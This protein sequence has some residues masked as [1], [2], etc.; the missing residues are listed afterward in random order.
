MQARGCFLSYLLYVMERCAKSKA[1]CMVCGSI[2]GAFQ[3]S[4]SRCAARL[5]R[6][7]TLLS[8][9][10]RRRCQKERDHWSRVLEKAETT[11]DPPA[12]RCQRTCQVLGPPPNRQDVAHAAVRCSTRQHR[13]ASVNDVANCDVAYQ[14]C[15]RESGI[16]SFRSRSIEQQGSASLP[17]VTRSVCPGGGWGG[18]QLPTPRWSFWRVCRDSS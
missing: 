13:A 15:R 11:L 16:V 14:R 4:T 8:S 1:V 10:G 6:L 12:L 17:T 7:P 3:T 18:S 2:N 5:L 9:R